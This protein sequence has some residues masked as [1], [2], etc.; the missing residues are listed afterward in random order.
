MFDID[1]NTKRIKITR[2]NYGIINVKATNENKENYVFQ[3]ND[4]IRL[5][6]YEKGNVENVVLQKDTK[7]NEITTEINVILEKNETL[8]GEPIS[9]SVVYW[10]DITLNPDTKP[11]TII[12]YDYDEEENIEK[13]KIFRL[14]PG[15]N[16][17]KESDEE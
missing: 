4:V 17:K 14:L 1:E 5:R 13:P 15:S 7:I 8:I 3:Q 6:V 16:E 10:Y 9:K 11:Q 2:G 12:G